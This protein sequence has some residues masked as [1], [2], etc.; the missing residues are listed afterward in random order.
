MMPADTSFEMSQRQWK[1][2]SSEEIDDN[3][4]TQHPALFNDYSMG[5]A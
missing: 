2:W 3:E 4:Q 5:A 1:I